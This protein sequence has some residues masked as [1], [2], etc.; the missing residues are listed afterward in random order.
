MVLVFLKQDLLIY[1]DSFLSFSIEKLSFIYCLSNI[2]NIH[3]NLL[4]K[5][6]DAFPTAL[7]LEI[8]HNKKFINKAGEVGANVNWR[9]SG[10]S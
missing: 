3:L 10:N 6:M 9:R 4:S 8:R 7:H 2:K 5:L 1:M